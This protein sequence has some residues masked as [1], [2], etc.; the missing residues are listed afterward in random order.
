MKTKILA[1]LL[2]LLLSMCCVSPLALAEEGAP[3]A[4][5]APT[6]PMIPGTNV[7][8]FKSINGYAYRLARVLDGSPDSFEAWL[9]M[10]ANSLGGTIVGNFFNTKFKYAGTV[11]WEVN[12]IGQVLVQWDNRTYQ[13]TF[14]HQPINDG[15]WHHIA[16]V[17]DAQA[18][19]FFLY[20]D[21]VLADEVHT[22]AGP[23]IATMPMNIG[24]DYRNWQEL[25]TPFEGSIRQVTMYTGAISQARILED[26]QNPHIT[27]TLEDTLLGNWYLGDAWKM[28][29][30]VESSGNGN[31]ATI[32]TFD[33]Y[34]GVANGGFEYDYMLV[35]IPDVQTMVRYNP[36]RYNSTMK[37]LA[38]N[39]ESQKM[40]FAFQVGD[41]SDDGKMED[42]FAV[43]AYG[44]NMRDLAA[45]LATGQPTLGI[46]QLDGKLPYSFVPGNHDY[47]DGCNAVRDT[48]YYNKY[49]PY[50][51]YS[52]MDNF[53][54]A[55]IEGQMDNYYV[56]YEVCGVKYLVLN[57]EFGPRL[58]VLRWAGRVC[59]AHPDYRVIV[60]THAYVDP[61]GEIMHEG[62]RYSATA[63]WKSA[64]VGQTTG[65]Q[66]WEGL[67]KRYSNIFMVFSGHNGTDD[68]V[69]RHDVGDHGN[70]ITSVLIDAQVVELTS[71]GIGHDLM[72][73]IKVN[74]Q[75]K[76]MSYCYY[77]PSYNM[78]FN[79]QNQFELS[80]A[81]ENNPT[82]G[83]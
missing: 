18:K 4:P 55:Y 73:M 15:A 80:F 26:M 53:G 8:E 16:V 39:A 22:L 83:K 3:T 38:D 20:I 42:L 56:K 50:A 27:D 7:Q 82:V 13:Y 44:Y 25:K 72:L 30:V 32:V 77:S 29:D 54:G 67:I 71:D 51:K 65:V 46:S 5:T 62:S 9:N 21:G 47:D 57:L 61:N 48:G 63:Y 58:S 69:V 31:D 76:T 23:A 6:S 70:K 34:L 14:D 41:L 35:G 1:L 2:V 11:N 60:S 10:P 45:V 52:Q 79:I 33:K 66:M 40:A 36:N 59:E 64:N 43:A 81:D 75:T 78:C 28:R 37:W 49:F 68:V 17:R 19:A 24:V 74:E 12:A